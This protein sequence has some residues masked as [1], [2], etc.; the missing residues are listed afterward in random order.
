VSSRPWLI[1]IPALLVAAVC[2]RLGVWQL[3]RLHQRRARNAAIIAATALPA[4]ELNTG[5]TGS[6]RTNRRARATGSFDRSHEVVLRSFEYQGAP[7]VRVVTPLRLAGSDSAVLVLRGFVD[8]PDAV[9]A[10]LDSLDEPGTVSLSGVLKEIPSGPDSGG[11]LESHGSTTWRRLDLPALRARTPY[12]LLEV[13]LIADR[14][15]THHGFPIRLEPEPLDD[16]PHLSYALQWFGF[17]ITAIVVGSIIG[18]KS[19]K[20]EKRTANRRD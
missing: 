17:A 6:I 1:L 15:S 14:D 20:S 13:Y 3:D 12:P 5:G 18:F 4:I 11:A 10:K 9:H 2:V 7:G 16:G 19:A 8:A